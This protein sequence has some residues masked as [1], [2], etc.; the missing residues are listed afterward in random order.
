M[1][2]KTK[3][4]E[5]IKGNLLKSIGED[6]FGY[7]VSE[8]GKEPYTNYYDNENFQFFI[9]EMKSSYENIYNSYNDGKGSE[10]YEKNGRY[11]KIPPKMA[12][13][14]SSSRFCYLALRDGANGLGGTGTVQFEYECRINGVPG[15]APQ[16]DAYIPNENIYVEVKCHEIFDSHKVVMK[17]K[18]WDFIY[19]ENNGFG[20]ETIEKNVED[21]F[22]IPLFVFG[23]EKTNT[24]FD[25]KQFLCH[26]LGISSQKNATDSATL[27]YMFFKPNAKSEVERMEIEE[28]FEV[29]KDEVNKIFNSTPI[30]RFIKN[31]NIELKAVAEYSE[32][33][34]SLNS[35]NMI[36]LF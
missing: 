4:D 17:E 7:V 35:E 31:N 28:V 21:T 9:D 22:E 24:M 15:T 32:V 25:I 27:V 26:L 12:S 13:V 20:L 33:M 14:A 34:E 8:S 3:F 6:V 2:N 36:T 1:M 16:L 19:R 30:Q 18:Y 23:I 10:L 11:G 5:I 29:L